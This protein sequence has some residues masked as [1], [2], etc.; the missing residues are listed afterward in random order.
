MQDWYQHLSP[1]VDRIVAI[2]GRI[3]GMPGDSAY[4]SDRSHAILGSAPDINSF[5][6][7]EPWASEQAKRSAYLVGQPGDWYVVVDADEMLMEGGSLYDAIDSLEGTPHEFA[8]IRVVG[9][10]ADRLAGRVFR[11][12]EGM[13]YQHRHFWLAVD[14]E[15]VWKGDTGP[16]LEDVYLQHRKSERSPERVKARASYQVEQAKLEFPYDR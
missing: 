3:V 11:H 13:C 6:Q 14:D 16:V 4:S 8:Q 7:S 1:H 5:S 2:D 9:Y 12:Q 15:I 10:G